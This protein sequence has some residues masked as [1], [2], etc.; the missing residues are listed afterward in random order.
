MLKAAGIDY[1]FDWVVD[2]VPNWMHTEQGP[3]LSVPYNLELNDSIIYAIEKHASDE[4]Y[5]RVAR[6][7][8]LFQRESQKRPRVMALGLH[9]HLIGVPHRFASFESMLDLLMTTPGVCF[10]QG[11]DIADWYAAQ[12]PPPQA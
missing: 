3:L 10:L 7:L 11:H 6:S 12:V 2:D 5:Q 4:M 9:P 1:V 8:A